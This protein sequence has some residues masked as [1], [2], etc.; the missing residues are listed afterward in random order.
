MRRLLLITV[1]VSSLMAASAVAQSDTSV[2]PE[3][4]I[5]QGGSSFFPDE[6][7]DM[8]VQS[9][10]IYFEASANQFLTT[11]ILGQT[12][13][14]GTSD[15]AEEIGDVNDIILAADGSAE[16]VVIG[17]GGFLDIGEKEVAIAFENINVV[18]RNDAMWL[19]INAGREDLE[20]APAFDRTLFED[21]YA[22]RMADNGMMSGESMRPMQDPAL[23]DNPDAAAISGS[24]DEDLIIGSVDDAI[25]EAN[26]GDITD[27]MSPVEFDALSASALIG[28][29]AFARN[30]QDIGEVGDIVFNAQGSVDA[31]I[32]DVGGFLG[33]AEKPVA[34]AA[35]DLDILRD[36]NGWLSVHTDLSKQ[37]LQSQPTFDVDAYSDDP[38]SVVLR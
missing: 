26:T 27:N 1:A 15:E 7:R 2:G 34:V 20:A 21:R 29:R 35:A 30:D 14:S 31:Y 37:Q 4:M 38:R 10:N 18:D 25:D 5:E 12:I 32:V 9:D 36:S 33:I 22:R 8:G 13:Y 11:N 16:A 28:A 3:D 23:P 17:V 6:N 19:T 24:L